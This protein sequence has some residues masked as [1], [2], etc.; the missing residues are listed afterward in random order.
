MIA[1][2]TI[3]AL[4]AALILAACS[5]DPSLGERSDGIA[6]DSADDA[7]G[8]SRKSPL[9]RARHAVGKVDEGDLDGGE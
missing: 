2:S 7:L 4:L 1:R 6:Q 8:F 3:P 9:V 5:A